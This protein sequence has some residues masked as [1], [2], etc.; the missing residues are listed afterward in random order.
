LITGA[1][2]DLG[3]T[4]APA[5]L[6]ATAGGPAANLNSLTAADIEGAGTPLAPAARTFSSPDPLV[7]DLANSIEAA[8]PGHVVG[9]NVPMTNASG[10]LVTDADIQLKNA[11][12]QVKSGGGVGLG[13]QVLRTAGATDLPVIGFGPNLQWSVVQ[14]IQNAGGL[15]TTD[16]DLLIQVIA[17]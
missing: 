17:P 8:Y 5:D 7:G 6:G 3:A 11:I 1:A 14:G 2:A 15:V 13:G 10:Q 16:Q 9:V 12:I 4:A